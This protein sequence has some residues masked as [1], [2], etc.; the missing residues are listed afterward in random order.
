MGALIALIPGISALAASI[1]GAVVSLVLSVGLGFLQ[2]ALMKKPK[3]HGG[4]ADTKV[5]IRQPN[6]P[7]RIVYGETRVAGT[8]IYVHTVQNNQRL[9][10]VIALAGHEVEE[11]GDI[12]FDDEIV[13]LD[14]SEAIANGGGGAATGKYADYVGIHKWLGTADQ[15]ADPQ[16]VYEAPDKWTTDHRLRGRAYLVVLMNYS[17]EKFPNGVPNITAVV[18]GK[19]VYDP[20]SD[21]TAWTDNAALC[22][23]DYLHDSSYGLG[24]AYDDEI[25]LD[26]L[27]AAAN[28]CDEEVDLAAGG[29][30]ARY[31]INGAFDT[32]GKP[33]D[34]LGD[35][36]NAMAGRAIHAGGRW[37]VIAGGWQVPAVTFDEDDLRGTFKVQ[38][39]LSRR[40]NFN[41]VK[42]TYISPDN[43]YQETDFPA[44]VSATYQA[45]DGGERVYKDVKLPYTATPAMAQRLAKIEL[46][47]ARQPITLPDVPFALSAYRVQCGDVIQLTIARMGWTAKAFE[48]TQATLAFD[49]D[50]NDKPLLGVNLS[51][52]ET[53]S[54]I[55]DWETSE[56]TAVDPAPNTDLPDVFDPLP[57]AGLAVA[58]ELYVTRDGAGV[59]TLARLSWVASADAFVSRYEIQYQLAGGSSWS[60]AR[61]TTETFIEIFDLAPGLY[62]FRVRGINTLQVRG[63]WV[64]VRATLNGLL[65]PPDALAGLTIA[66]IG[67]LAVLRWTQS[68][69]LDVR[70]GGHIEFRHSPDTGGTAT[71]ST[72]T[73]IG[74]AVPGMSTFAVL[75]LKPGTYLAKPRDSAGVYATAAAMVETEQATSLEYANIDSL[76]ED[77]T[78]A[79]TH[80]DTV[81]NAG[82]D[83][84]RLGMSSLPIDDWPDVDAV[85]DWDLEGAY[86]APEGS[87]EFAG[88]FD[89]GSVTRVRLTAH[90]KAQV[91]NT[92]DLIS[93]RT[94]TIDTWPSI[95]G[96]NDAVAD[97]RVR[98]RKTNDDP[99]GTPTWTDWQRLDSMELVGRGFEFGCDLSTQQPTYNIH[100]S[101]LR[102]SVDEV[103]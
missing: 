101:E 10:L 99:A 61:E 14:G 54:S 45:E 2:K 55:F 35:M 86:V 74:E 8:Y 56:E 88:G 3:A 29:T 62:D 92:L 89:L 70:I 37:R 80:D 73:S 98:V 94:G 30:Q 79:G 75:P 22:V 90:I 102:I 59:K 11:I 17:Q 31:T 97:A 42:G 63:A 91:I 34:I 13:P 50:A 20:R 9:Q 83:T 24:A 36:I 78:F 64:T 69:D 96:D 67:G 85:A 76:A 95:D 7:W 77:P 40:E 1:L 57:P 12:W 27:S 71:W 19:K 33:V 32:D 28:I 4:Q 21:T 48:V 25:D 49:R 16:L 84:L 51:L 81:Y 68:P 44:V 47:R 38:T 53:D 65:D 46:L 93:L 87:Y 18:K 39:L 26:A 41:A 43:K 5:T 15:I 23:A 72:S 103:A 100:V 58:E 66:T 6:S 52:R 60:T 82:D